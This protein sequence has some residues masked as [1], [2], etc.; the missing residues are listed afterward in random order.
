MY[1]DTYVFNTTK[2]RAFVLPQFYWC[3]P[4]SM[5]GQSWVVRLCPFASSV[6]VQFFFISLVMTNVG[7][8]VA[9]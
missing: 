5:P 6:L 9:G 2:C 7:L 4:L 1:V 3:G 8:E